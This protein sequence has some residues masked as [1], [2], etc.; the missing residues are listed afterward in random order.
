M[1]EFAW[2]D[3]P[4][5][6]N[7]LGAGGLIQWALRTVRTYLGMDVA[8]VSELTEDRAVFRNVDAPGLEDQI[9]AGDTRKLDEI[10]CNSVLNGRLPELIP[11]TAAEPVAMAMEI[12]RKV[13]IGAH[14]SVPIV[15][16]DS[17]IYG[18]F[19]CFAFKA[20]PELS[21]KML[22]LMRAMAQ[23][24]GI[25]IS[26]QMNASHRKAEIAEHIHSAI[27]GE[28]VSPVY[29][30][31]WDIETCRPAG[32]EC[33]IRFAGEPARPPDEWLRDA[34]GIGL[35]HRLEIA[36]MEKALSD[37][38]SLP[39][40]LYLSINA[41][42]R[43]LLHRSFANALKRFSPDR[44]VLEL[45]E[46]AP[47]RNYPHIIEALRS[48]REKGLRLAIDD[49]GA[50]YATMNHILNLEPDFI[51]LDASLIRDID[52]DPARR[53]LVSALNVFARETD[54]KVVAEGVETAGELATLQ[55]IG[56][57]QAQGFY[58][59]RPMK[60]AT[61]KRVLASASR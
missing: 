37:L 33:L 46:H 53:S 3:N 23:L 49:V 17:S 42:A 29:Q 58:L 22:T 57:H 5:G 31:I 25:E 21:L 48:F 54:C 8:Y 28:N 20:H 4:T 60:P 26:G 45:T 51:K 59:G 36:V 18:M 38:P 1:T 19:C 15:L 6:D 50:G 24:A 27:R 11:D 2:S 14:V 52:T 55:T 56:V 35:R 7:A 47:I 32:L 34:G 43:T 9:K 39:D 40:D 10:Y 61:A 41:S 44:T 16:S 12:T 13:P 30:L